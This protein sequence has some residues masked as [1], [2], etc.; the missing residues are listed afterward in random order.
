MIIGAF[1][2]DKDIVVVPIQL[3]PSVP[4]IVYV[5][6]AHS[7]VKLPEVG[8]NGPAGNMLKPIGPVPPLPLTLAVPSQPGVQLGSVLAVI[9]TS[10]ALGSVTFT[11]V[12]LV[13][14]FTSVPVIV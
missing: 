4:V 10:T 2:V 11:T 12:V 13:Q 3:L 6:P 9:F 8:C 14:P 7:P 1:G 5:V